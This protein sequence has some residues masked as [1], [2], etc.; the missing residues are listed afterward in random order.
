MAR[1]PVAAFYRDKLGANADG[2]RLL[3]VID[4]EIAR[5]RTSGPYGSYP[6]GPLSVENTAGL[7]YRVSAAGKTAL[8]ARLAAAFE[9]AHLLVFRPA[10]PR[11]PT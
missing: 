7:I 5:G 1:S 4:A 11:T 3:E 10:M 6:A 9:Q 2:A 8:G